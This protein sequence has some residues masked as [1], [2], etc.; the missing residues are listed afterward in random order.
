MGLL[1]VGARAAQVLAATGLDSVRLV[2]QVFAHIIIVNVRLNFKC[3]N[4]VPFV[5]ALQE[6]L[7]RI[8]IVD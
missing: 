5:F 4:L 2:K 1:D 8:R 3:S 6:E 7:S